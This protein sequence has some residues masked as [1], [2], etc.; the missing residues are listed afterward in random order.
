MK[1]KKN[2]KLAIVLFAMIF[3]VG[4]AFAATNGMLAFGGT[5]RINSTSTVNEAMLEFD[6]WTRIF[7]Y[8]QIRIHHCPWLGTPECQCS[9]GP[10]PPNAFNY[11]EGSAR[12]IEENGRQKLA[13]DIDILDIE[14][15]LGLWPWGIPE[16]EI[17]G[18]SFSF[19]NTGSVPVR[20]FDFEYSNDDLPFLLVLFQHY[21]PT[22]RYLPFYTSNLPDRF[23]NLTNRPHAVDSYFIVMPGERIHGDFRLF[24]HSLEQFANSQDGYRFDSWFTLI[25]E[26]AQ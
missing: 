15:L 3:A 18:F 21:S 5:V 25:Y 2:L 11:F 23:R 6:S 17:L 26:Q 8:P 9:L 7:A 10:P 24:V 14:A 12:I 1:T 20:L 19:Q 4:A 22:T 13:F 16:D